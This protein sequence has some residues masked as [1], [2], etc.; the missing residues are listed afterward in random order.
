MQYGHKWK[1][2]YDKKNNN[3]LIYGDFQGKY[4]SS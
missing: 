1:K 4:E 2:K 3:N